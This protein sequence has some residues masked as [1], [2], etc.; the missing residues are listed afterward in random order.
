MKSVAEFYRQK[1]RTAKKKHCCDTCSH[2]V[3]SGERY[4]SVAMKQ[5]GSFD[6]ACYCEECA[7][8][9]EAEMHG[10]ERAKAVDA[11]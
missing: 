4:L 10:Y 6:Y 3:Q 5:D 9:R 11:L 1:W 8:E 7:D 2:I